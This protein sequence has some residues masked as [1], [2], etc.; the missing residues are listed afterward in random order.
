MFTEDKGKSP[1]GNPVP[2]NY[3]MSLTQIQSDMVTWNSND[4]KTKILKNRE[5]DELHRGPNNLVNRILNEDKQG[6]AL[7]I[8]E[9][10][11]MTRYPKDSIAIMRKDLFLSIIHNPPAKWSRADR[12]NGM[13]DDDL[14]NSY[15]RLLNRNIPNF[16]A[17]SH[18]DLDVIVNKSKVGAAGFIDGFSKYLFKGDKALFKKKNNGTFWVKHREK[19]SGTKI[20]KETLPKDMRTQLLSNKLTF[21]EVEIRDLALPNDGY[22]KIKT[23]AGNRYYFQIQQEVKHIHRVVVF[24]KHKPAELHWAL[25]VIN[26]ENFTIEHYDSIYSNLEIK[27][28]TMVLNYIKS[29]FEHFCSMDS[30]VYMRQWKFVDFSRWKTKVTPLQNGIDCGF[31]VME[32]AKYIALNWKITKTKPNKNDFEKIRRR[33]IYE[34]HQYCLLK[35]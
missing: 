10:T 3:P 30:S 19:P 2:E 20:P 31:F 22:V 16:S 33:C 25:V 18:N 24:P 26:F 15:M 5:D 17:Y 14:V 27:V 8:P 7:V 32:M 13:A 6:K 28:F 9:T 34:L 1:R 11:F 35:V 12:T 4:W 23:Q 29:S 21:T